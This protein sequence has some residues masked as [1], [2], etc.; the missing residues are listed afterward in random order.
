MG[1]TWW[2]SA[3]GRAGMCGEEMR[4]G[5]DGVVTGAGSGVRG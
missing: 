2:E 1:L 5:G 4:E 3:N